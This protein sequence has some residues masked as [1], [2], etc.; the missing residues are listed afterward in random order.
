MNDRAPESG[1]ILEAR[2]FLA[3]SNEIAGRSEDLLDFFRYFDD[4]ESLSEVWMRGNWDFAHYILK[5]SVLP[6]L[7][8]PYEKRVLEIGYGG[9]RLLQAACRYFGSGVGVDVHGNAS[10]VREAIESLDVSNFELFQTDGL[11]MPMDDS[12]IDF[13][14][15]FIVLQHLPTLQS[16]R[17]VLQE[18]RRVIRPDGIGILYFG[19]LRSGLFKR[20]RF[21][22]AIRSKTPDVRDVTLRLT[23]PFARKLISQTG[24]DVHEMG[25]SQKD[26]WNPAH[27]GQFYVVLRPR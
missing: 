3:W 2:H 17:A 15:S 18:L 19:Y 11:S 14:Y 7:N 9:G 13:A 23:M 12:S 8:N 1:G 6:Y 24:Y 22:E 10:L 20:T 25:R 5:P 16:L 27:G 26:P 4:A 21:E